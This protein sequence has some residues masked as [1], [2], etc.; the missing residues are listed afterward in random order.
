MDDL[1]VRG[2]SHL[3]WRAYCLALDLETILRRM[4]VSEWPECYIISQQALLGAAFTL[5]MIFNIT[6]L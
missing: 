3:G 1:D 2:Y 6:E 4:I 5:M